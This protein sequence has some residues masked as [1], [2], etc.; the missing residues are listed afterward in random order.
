MSTAS[1]VADEPMGVGPECAP[2]L[3]RISI[4][5]NNTELTNIRHCSI[6]ELRREIPQKLDFLRCK[7]LGCDNDLVGKRRGAKFCCD[8]H[9]KIY[10]RNP[11]QLIQRYEYLAVTCGTLV[12]DSRVEPYQQ[13]ISP[14]LPATKMTPELAEAT[15]L[16]RSRLNHWMQYVAEP[17][18]TEGAR[19]KPLKS[20]SKNFDQRKAVAKR[21]LDEAHQA[22]HVLLEQQPLMKDKTS[23]VKVRIAPDQVDPSTSLSLPKDVPVGKK[24][25]SKATIAR[26]ITERKDYLPHPRVK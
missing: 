18:F 25:P 20:E 13:L 23:V 5:T 6:G 2:D 9:R 24:K 19:P 16:Y 15:M 26:I 14:N 17:K 12:K 21:L 4:P 8:L 1:Q 3:R 22:L 10:F 7:L 11:W